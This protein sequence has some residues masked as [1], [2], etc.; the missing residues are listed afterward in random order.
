[1]ILHIHAP[2][3]LIAIG[4]LASTAAP[5]PSTFCSAQLL[6]LEAAAFQLVGAAFGTC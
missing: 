6:R 3:P 4:V 1:M 5:M 2:N